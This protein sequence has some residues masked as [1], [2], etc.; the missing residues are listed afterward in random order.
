[1]KLCV[2][3]APGDVR[4][5]AAIGV[6]LAS[7]GH[8]VVAA[9]EASTGAYDL[10][11]IAAA[12]DGSDVVVGLGSAGPWAASVAEL[13]RAVG[14]VAAVDPPLPSRELAPLVKVRPPEK[15]YRPVGSVLGAWGWV[16]D[17]REVNRARRAVGLGPMGN[18]FH[19]LP[20][21]GAWSPTLVP[22][23]ADWDTER[24]TVTG[25]WWLADDLA[26]SPDAELAA[27]LTVGDR[28]IYVGFGAMTGSPAEYALEAILEA[29]ADTY[30]I[31]LDAGSLPVRSEL[32]E[33]VHRIESV[34]SEWLFS[35]CGALV[36]ESGAARAHAAAR[37]GI[38][39]IPVPFTASQRFWGDRLY[40]AGIATKPVDPRSGWE[41]YKAALRDTLPLRDPAKELAGR[42]SAEDG[43]TAA[44]R[45]LERLVAQTH[46]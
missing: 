15:L 41:A 39:T 38:P 19:E 44:V 45:A 11:M 7:A 3:G 13:V 31:L 17:G 20:V 10:G 33:N 21:L 36:F 1:M 5:V 23:P 32:P 35:R 34:P 37:S 30:R 14:V 16:R 24:V 27:F 9:S 28:P 6:G 46:L 22:T 8:E 25:E 18:P 42:I 40:G 4:A 2:V 29:W 12:A 26:W 43:V